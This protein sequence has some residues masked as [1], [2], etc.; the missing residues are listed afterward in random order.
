MTDFIRIFHLLEL[1]DCS[2]Q[3]AR[4]AL[5]SSKLPSDTYQGS[6]QP[7]GRQCIVKSL[8]LGTEKCHS[9]KNAGSEEN[10]KPLE[11]WSRSC[12]ACSGMLQSQ[13]APLNLA[14]LY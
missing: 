2:V 13:V 7:Y 3:Y 1:A 9:V 10:G 11:G 5:L 8:F 12:Q 6:D 14:G 4:C